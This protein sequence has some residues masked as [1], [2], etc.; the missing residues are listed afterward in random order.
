MNC[1]AEKN[2]ITKVV[3]DGQTKVTIRGRWAALS[4]SEIGDEF[5]NGIKSNNEY[6]MAIQSA[7]V[8][9]VEQ[10]PRSS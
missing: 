4:P 8:E 9:A 3:N 6:C 7:M 1:T 10:M 5:S 2:C